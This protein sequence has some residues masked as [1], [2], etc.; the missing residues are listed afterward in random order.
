MNEDPWKRNE[1]EP[2]TLASLTVGVI[3]FLLI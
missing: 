2:I 1:K 3:G